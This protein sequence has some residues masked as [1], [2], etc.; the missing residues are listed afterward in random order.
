M[1]IQDIVNDVKNEINI[2]HKDNPD[3]IIIIRWATATWKSKLS[4]LLSEF[5]DIEIISADS[6]QIFKYMDIWTDKVPS[7]ILSKITHHQINII[8]PDDI[9]TAWQRKEDTEKIINQIKNNKKIPVIVWWTG[10]YIDTIYKNFSMPSCPPDY[11]LRK[12]LE[13]KEKITPWIL[14]QELMKIDPEEAKKLHPNST[15]YIVRALEIFYKTNNTKTKSYLQA[16]P[17]WPILMIWLWR[18]KEDTD[19][20]INIRIQEMIQ[21][22]LTDEVKSLIKKWYWSDLQSMQWIWYKET[23]QYINWN[24]NLQELE[25]TLKK[26]THHLAKKQRT[27]FRRYISEAKAMPRENI[28]YKVYM[29]S[30]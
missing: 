24:Y 28:T 21:S 2:F 1:E 23:I 7:K 3:W 30:C 13:D 22:W 16:K 14:Y 19:N 6:R 11:E 29:L 8:N 5:F 17:K 25:E 26:N 4:I 12:Q 10:L 9:Y 20:R 15:R 18:E 27:R